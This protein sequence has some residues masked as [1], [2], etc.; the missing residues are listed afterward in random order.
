MLMY[1]KYYY[2]SNPEGYQQ[3]VAQV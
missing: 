3:R 2:S 1:T